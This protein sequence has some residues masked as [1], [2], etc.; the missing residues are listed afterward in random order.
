MAQRRTSRTTGR[1]GGFT[2]IELMVVLALIGVIAAMALP[3]LLPMVIYS[4]H[5]GAARHLA[6]YG[7]SAIAH[8]S[9]TR[10]TI[11]V[12]IDLESQEYWCES[13]PE[14]EESD[15]D[16][17]RDDDEE[18]PDDDVELFRMARDELNR[19]EDERG[20][21]E[22]A[23]LINEQTSRMAT[24]FNDRSNRALRAR[25]NRVVHDRRGILQGVGDL[26]DDDFR[27][28]ADG[29]EIV[30]EEIS[31]PL[32]GR[33]RLPEGVYIEYV[34]LGEVHYIDEIVEIELT[35]LGLGS[36][37][38]FSLVNEDGDVLTV[39]WDPVTGNASVSAGGAA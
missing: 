32:I 6:N 2:Y 23:K 5:E 36:D 22:G 30:P 24:Q 10:E 28:G 25:A 21:E 33:T 4:T 37:V 27:I 16:M 29:E 14:P 20:S 12:M 39:R 15:D 17:F 8:A 3:R 26:L 38:E 31:D 7:R 11:T 19:P 13:L 34:K 35:P 1:C 18:F 9:F